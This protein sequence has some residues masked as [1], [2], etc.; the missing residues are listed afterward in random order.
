M[1]PPPPP[2]P[3]GP[4]LLS[5]HTITVM[6]AVTFLMQG[7][8][9]A[10]NSVMVREYKGVRTA[11]LATLSLALGFGVLLLPELLSLRVSGPASN[12]L[13]LSGHTL[14]YLAICRFIGIRPNRLLVYGIVPAG[15]V[16][17]IGLAVLSPGVPLIMVTQF[18]GLFLNLAAAI[19]LHR[20]GNRRFKLGAYLTALPLLLYGLVTIVRLITGFVSPREV[21]PG[22]TLSNI[23]DVLALYVLSYL[24]IAGFILMISQRL[25]SDLNDLAMNDALTRVRNRRAMQGMLDFEMRRVHTEPKDFSVILLDV[26]HFKRI[27]DTHGHD[28]GDAVLQWLAQTLQSALRV[29]DIVARWGGEEFLVLLPDTSLEESIR[30]ADRLRV[31][32]EKSSTDGLP[33]P[34]QLTFSAGVANS[35]T[36]RNVDQLCKVADRAL[37]IAK[38]TRNQ[39]VS[40]DD[41]PAP[42]A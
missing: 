15:A 40:Q 39:V 32:V 3:G 26:D 12:L 28:V 35:K 24:W 42:A 29:Q 14:I 4:V 18:V 33:V 17:L 13:I 41:L 11:F 16:A 5:L 34:L 31:L 10:F 21:L 30:M 6:I 22:P 2:P 1:Q 9:I 27:N 38:Q 20:A 7:G 36:N 23:F 25:Q 19:A 8:A 37:Y